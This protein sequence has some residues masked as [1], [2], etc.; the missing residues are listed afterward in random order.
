MKKSV[1]LIAGLSVL[2]GHAEAQSSVTLYGIIDAGVTHLSNSNGKPVYALTSGVM[3]G[4]RWGFRGSEDLG[5]GYKAV[6]RLENG[7]NVNNGT[8]GQGGLEFGRQAYVGLEAPF[9][10]VTLGRQYDSVVDYLGP[11]GAAEQ[12]AGSVSA[13]PGDL[14]NINNTFRTNNSIK[15]TSATLSGVTFGGLYG[16]GGVAGDFTRNQVFSLGASYAG[17]PLALAA[18]YLNVRNGN[19]GYFGNSSQTP[20]TSS[21]GNISSPVYSGF[22][23]AHTYQVMS[24]GGAYSLGAATLGA[25][26][27]NVKFIGLG[28]TSTGPNKSGY[29]G[30]ATFNTAEVNF[31]YQITPAWVGGI[32]Y[33]YT[34]SNG[35][36]ANPGAKYQQAE[37]SVHYSFSKRTETYV[38][39]TYQRA[40]GTDSTGKPAVAAINLQTPSTSNSQL[41]LRVGLRH[42]F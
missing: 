5:G 18:A 35:V 25:I 3:S 17:G 39:A 26:Y 20:L 2:A 7:F 15:Y 16:L 33:A 32:A 14:D 36:D 37:A 22:A 11:L 30:T 38:L 4:S 41:L 19:V 34:K 29:T 1:W 40:S 23:S 24:A 27:S 42:T 31:R 21:T 10:T 6:F 28:D 9:G 13:H 8:F 12:W